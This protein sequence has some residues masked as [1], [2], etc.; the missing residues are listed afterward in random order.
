MRFEL[1]IDRHQRE[2]AARALEDAGAP[3]DPAD[4]ARFRDGARRVWAR[5][6]AA[7]ART[8]PS[9]WARGAHLVDRWLYERRR[10]EHIDD[11]TLPAIARARLQRSLDRLNR[12]VG[13]YHW[14]SGALERLLVE[15]GG[16]RGEVSVLDLGSGHGAFPIHLA[17]RGRLAGA[18]LRVVGSDLVPAYVEAARAAAARAGVAVEF[19]RVDALELDRLDE[20][21][22]VIVCTQTVHHFAPESLAEL[23]ARARSNARRGVLLFDARRSLLSL[24]L[25]APGLLALSGGDPMFLHDGVVSLRRMYSPA[26]LELLARCAPGGESF[27]AENHGPFYVVAR[28]TA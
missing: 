11:P 21:F 26:E 8:P 16:A 14:I 3:F 10:E 18:R 5:Y 9:L 2:L 22:D 4:G 15:T 19:R 24:A 28:A 25:L 20:R 6:Q 17:A 27:S 23:M 1:P 12:A 13:T 7:R